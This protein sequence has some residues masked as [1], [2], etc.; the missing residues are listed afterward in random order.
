MELHQET[1][2]EDV[3]ELGALQKLQMI[4]HITYPLDDL[5]GTIVLRS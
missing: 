5:V 1:D 4:C 2:M 3:M